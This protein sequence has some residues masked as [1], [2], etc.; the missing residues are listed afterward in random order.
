MGEETQTITE[1]SFL[2]LPGLRLTGFESKPAGQDRKLAGL[3]WLGL[4]GTVCLER[5]VSTSRAVT[6]G[7]S[8][9]HQGQS[10]H[11]KKRLY[12]YFTAAE[13]LF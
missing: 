2:V 1:M 4:W 5:A 3:L 6:S 13:L 11:K 8:R 10:Q 12:T 7:V 9:C